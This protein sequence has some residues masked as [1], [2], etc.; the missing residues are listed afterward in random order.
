MEESPVNQVKQLTNE[1]G[2]LKIA[3]ASAFSRPVLELMRLFTQEFQILRL[4]AEGNSVEMIRLLRYLNDELPKIEDKQKRVNLIFFKRGELIKE[5]IKLQ[6]EVDRL[7]AKNADWLLQ[8]SAVKRVEEI[9]KRINLLGAELIKYQKG[10]VITD[11]IIV[12]DE[13]DDPGGTKLDEK[14]KPTIESLKVFNATVKGIFEQMEQEYR[15]NKLTI[16]EYFEERRDLARAVYK[17]EVRVLTDLLAKTEDENDQTKIR[18]DLKAKE[19]GLQTTLNRLKFEEVQAE[20]NLAKA[21][22]EVN[23]LL[24]DIEKRADIINSA[25]YR[26]ELAELT[27]RQQEEKD[28][29]INSKLETY[30]KERALKRAQVAWEKE[31]DKLLFDFTKRTQLERLDLANQVAGGILTTF[32][33]LYKASGEKV[34]AFFVLSRLAAA[35][36]ATVSGAAAMVKSYEFDPYGFLAGT[37]AL[38]T[39]TQVGTI[40][41]TTIAGLYEGG[42]IHG[43]G[44]RD[45][46]PA[47]LTNREFVQPTRSVDYYGTG[48]M[49]A[50]R[51]RAIPKEVF[52]GFGGLS[53]RTSSRFF[54]EG[55]LAVGDQPGGTALQINNIVDPELFGDY[56]ATSSGED[57][58]LNVITKRSYEINQRLRA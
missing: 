57:M 52:T 7:A 25:Q 27:A 50:M 49:E 43:P 39:A 3:V 11:P 19:I 51:Q 37:I 1:I 54:N 8:E 23:T 16:A 30:E 48:I 58:V 46:I 10:F 2:R 14:I 55:G 38:A 34:K 18:N 45:V 56:L 12:T 53:P 40:L 47:M 24:L 20:E 31:Q 36:Q 35:A 26:R 41:G 33:N 22:E 4:A 42:Q 5:R 6:K 44:G 32:D 15:N 17:E 9:T 29:I 13:D 28:I 21:K